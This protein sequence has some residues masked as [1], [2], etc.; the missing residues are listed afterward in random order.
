MTMQF[1]LP[2][3]PQGF[4]Q[5]PPAH[6]GWLDGYIHHFSP[7]SLRMLKICPE[8]YR[9]RYILG[10]KERPAERLLIGKVA[11]H[12]L[13]F[14]DTKKITSGEDLPVPVVV[15]Y[16]HDKSWPEKL[17]KD[18]G[19]QEVR[20]ESKP[21]DARRDAER[22]AAAY[23][24][25][26]NPRVKPVAV[27]KKIEYVIPGVPV[28]VIGYIDIVEERN[29]IDRKFG[30][31]VQKKADANWRTQGSIYAAA[32]GLPTH[33]HSTSKAKTPSIATPL[34]SG[35]EMIVG[36][37]QQETI[38]QL[39][40]FHVKMLE[41]LFNTYGPDEPWPTTGVF[42]DYKGGAACAFCGFRKHCVAWTHER[43]VHT[44]MNDIH[45]NPIG[46]AV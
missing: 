5:P 26:V 23:H 10:R 43:V 34:E 2:P 33:F 13:A 39:I 16:L 21:D 28:P 22:M 12:A 32:T 3:L 44:D 40:L 45:G 20:W 46:G 27:E 11:H 19:E 29:T 38:H 4:E 35:D 15:E 41:H 30:K 42:M 17:E 7:S 9:Q 36:V 6:E 31:Q 18:G 24:T 14:S 8:Q 25:T 1:E 37:E